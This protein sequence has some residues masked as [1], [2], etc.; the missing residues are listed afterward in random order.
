MLVVKKVTA[1]QGDVRDAGSIP[2]SRK[3]PGR[4]YGN[5][6]QY[7]C[8]ANPMDRGDWWAMVHG[9]PSFLKDITEAI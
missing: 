3:S 1:M 9:G 4:G 8:L 6:F 7:P 5:P 2:G